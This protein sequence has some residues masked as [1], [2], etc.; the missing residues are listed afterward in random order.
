MKIRP[1]A[2]SDAAIIADFNCRLAL[3]TEGRQLDPALVAMGVSGLMAFPERGVY[4]VA[5]MDGRVIGQTLITYEWS[6]WRNGNFW[7]IQSVYVASDFRK[8]GIF[9]ALYQHV[10]A[11]AEARSDVC[12]LRLYVEAENEHAQQAYE[13]LGM[14]RT[15]YRLYELEFDPTT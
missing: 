13:R 2:P 4:Y 11:A 5:E 15:P 7:W 1:A 6:D 3:E 8:Q 12:G 10:K 9:R 14:K